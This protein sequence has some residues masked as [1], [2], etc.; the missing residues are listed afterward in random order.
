V[1]RSRTMLAALLV[2]GLCVLPAQAEE[3]AKEDADILVTARRL[4]TPSDRSGTSISSISAEDLEA[5]QTESLSDVLR[6]VPGVWLTRGGGQGGSTSIFI[7]GAA[8]NQ[9]KVL[10]DGFALNDPTIG[11]QYN[12][13]DLVNEG[14][15]RV[16]V[17]RGSQSAL[18]GSEAIGGVV[19]LVSRSYRGPLSA[20]VTASGGSNVSGR[21]GFE[22]GGGDETVSGGF[23]FSH[24]RTQNEVDR[25]A[26][27]AVTLGGRLELQ[28][29]EDLAVALTA[30]WIDSS[31]QDPYDFGDPLVEDEN[32]ERLRTTTLLG[33]ETTWEALDGV[34][35][36][37]RASVMRVESTFNNGPD[38]SGTAD[39]L[40]SESTA[41]VSGFALSATVETARLLGIEKKIAHDRLTVGYEYENAKSRNE[42]VS[43]FG[44]TELKDTVN[45][46]AWIIQEE[47][48]L[49]ERVD[50]TVGLRFTHNDFF[51]H[52]TAPSYALQYNHLET[53]TTLAASHAVGFRAPTPI[54][55]ADPFVGNPD[56][57][58][59]ESESFDVGI[60]QSLL[61]GSLVLGATWFELSVD[62]LIAW[63]PTTWRLENFRRTRT[64]GLEFTG[65]YDIDERWSLGASYTHQDPRDLD[66]PRG[67]E[68]QLPNRPEDF[69]SLWAQ[70]ESG[71]L[72]VT[73][74][75]M[76]SGGFE[77]TGVV[78]PDQR[79]R[80]HP[81][82]KTL[83]NLAASYEITEGA[84]LLGRIENL[85]DD[86]YV[87]VETGPRSAGFGLFLG[88]ELRF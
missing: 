63:D 78:G 56:L 13:F 7:R 37:A 77:G 5:R 60:R 42:T 84:R 50:A 41:D 57:T 67:E 15:D 19:Q 16:E 54:E 66:A 31:A 10:L 88:L 22:I 28:P 38:I 14:L 32:I 36:R 68:D 46:R 48:T 12:A 61:E 30:R 18:Y 43:P 76:I 74:T 55:F 81:G 45:D 20:R 11:G 6:E 52:E 34:T 73:A 33:M 27:E 39:E 71:G 85:L 29:F 25:N 62:D 1:I 72:R 86:E 83:V 75:A 58:Q 4:P 26:F 24:L 79:A 49:F 65:R 2:A 40:D 69:G 35:V 3:D 64:T 8:S 87:E 59:E 23:V 44:A 21:V 51:G 82:K 53:G 47:V 9:T 70:Y 80:K 17:L